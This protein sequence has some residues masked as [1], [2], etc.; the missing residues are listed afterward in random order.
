V[1]RQGLVC[2][3]EGREGGVADSAAW[4]ILLRPL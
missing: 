1:P 4:I 2:S 3:V